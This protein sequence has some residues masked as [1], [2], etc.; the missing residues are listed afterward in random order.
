MYILPEPLKVD[1]VYSQF[2]LRLKADVSQFSLPHG[3][4]N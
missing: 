2:D 1:E 3:T 4:E